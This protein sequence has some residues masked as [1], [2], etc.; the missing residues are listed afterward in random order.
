M[1]V[2]PYS[3]LTRITN[4]T[5]S[6]FIYLEFFF[7]SNLSCPL[8]CVVTALSISALRFSVQ[9]NQ[10]PNRPQSL[11][12]SVFLIEFKK[13]TTWVSIPAHN[14]LNLCSPQATLFPSS[15]QISPPIF[16]F[17]LKYQKEY[18]KHRVHK[19]VLFFFGT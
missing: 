17:S 1:P 7:T 12:K 5:T 16:Q 9:L 19:W 18:M 2:I 11:T 14:Q 4:H 15:S 6:G 13:S 10:Y 3:I 8:F